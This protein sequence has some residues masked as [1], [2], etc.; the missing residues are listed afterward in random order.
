MQRGSENSEKECKL[1]SIRTT[2]CYL[3]AC[4][5]STCKKYKVFFAVLCKILTNFNMIQ[6]KISSVLYPGDI[7]YILFLIAENCMCSLEFI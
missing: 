3:S 6:L 5:E 1:L 4:L 2:M 7:Q